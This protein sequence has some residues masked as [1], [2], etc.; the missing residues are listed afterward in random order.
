[1]NWENTQ[2]LPPGLKGR[3]K[4]RSLGVGEELVLD[5]QDIQHGLKSGII[6]TVTLWLLE[7]E[8]K[9]ENTQPLPPGWMGRQEGRSL[10]F[11]YTRKVT[12]Y[13]C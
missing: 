3:E 6:H 11:G 10:V 7:D 12:L 1:M 2:A 9:W 8:V 4:G 5:H 13:S